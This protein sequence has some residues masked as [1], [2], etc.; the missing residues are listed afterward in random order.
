MKQLSP[1]TLREV[2][3]PLASQPEFAPAEIEHLIHAI[4]QHVRR[5]VRLRQPS[6][7]A[8]LPFETEPVPWSDRGRFLIDS[9]I[10]PGGHLR[11]AAGQYAIQ[12]AASLLPI[13]LMQLA[14]GQWVCDVC[15]APGGKSWAILDQ[16]AGD[17]L[18]LS[19]EVI[20]SRVDTLQLA[21]A[22][23]GYSNYLMTHRPA[24]QLVEAAREAFDCVLVDAPCTGQ[25]L[26]ARGKQ[27]LSAFTQKQIAHSAA[28]QQTI[29]RS[30]L[31]LVRPGGRLVYSTCTF[32]FEENEAIVDWL[33]TLVPTWQPVVLDLLSDWQTPGHPGCYRLWP[34]RDQCSGGF[35]A[36]V[37]RPLDDDGASL[38]VQLAASQ[39]ADNAQ[40]ADC[41]QPAN[42]AQRRA[43]RRG[44]QNVFKDADLW[45]PWSEASEIEA[46]GQFVPRASPTERALS[47]QRA[48][49]DGE[50]W[51]RRH[52]AHWFDPRIP[53]AW[54]QISHA[55]I[56]V[57]AAFGDHWQPSY[58]L[59][60]ASELFQP[61]AT[62]E[63]SD[64]E[65]IQFLSGASLHRAGGAD[66]GGAAGW[67]VVQWRGQSLGWAKQ[68]GSQL[69]NHL[70]KPLRQ[71]ALSAA[72]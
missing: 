33:R 19:N 5:C 70:P 9:R 72:P 41:A 28:R 46:W 57:A 64:A 31:Q 45:K 52:R 18:L 37:V 20:A 42:N 36:A 17:G 10:R 13:T 22:R 14:P 7:A 2:L 8:E 47:E 34:H 68:V 48:G 51:Q 62:V 6:R 50:L 26:V 1:A 53:D 16:L 67:C 12:D 61:H 21:L 23:S 29:L 3:G 71:P 56:E 35:A 55:G 11:F 24:E 43:E 66:G 69:K 27:S 65:A 59:A 44:K 63:L 25:S 4:S 54:R 38:E 49:H 58:P 40:L 30:A 15:A 60:T 32:A 39:L